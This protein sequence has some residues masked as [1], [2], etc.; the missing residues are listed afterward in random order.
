M[1]QSLTLL[2]FKDDRVQELYLPL[3]LSSLQWRFKMRLRAIPLIFLLSATCHGAESADEVDSFFDLPLQD[4]L[5][6][7]VVTASGHTQSFKEAPA[8]LSVITAD[9]IARWQY[10]SVGEALQQVPGIHC[11]NDYVSLNCGVRGINGGLKGYSKVLKVMIDGQ[12]ISF[13]SDTTNYLGPELIPITVIERIEV[14]RS[15]TSALYG[16]NAFLGVINIITKMPEK[17]GGSLLL[18][19][20]SQQGKPGYGLATDW[21]VS[22][23]HGDFSI[24]VSQERATRDGLEIPDTLPRNS[25]FTPGTENRN[26]ETRPASAYL[27]WRYQLEKHQLYLQGHYSHLDSDAQFVDFG[28]FKSVGELGYNQRIALNNAFIKI[29][30]DITFTDTFSLHVALAYAEGSPSQ[31]E[32]LDVGLET[33]IPVR[34]FGFKATDLVTEINYTPTPQHFITLG[35]DLANDNEELFEAFFENRETGESILTTKAQG[36][37]TFRERGYY[38]QYNGNL[39][40]NMAV[41]LNAR[42]DDHNIYGNE[43]T[44][45]VGVTHDIT[46][47][48]NT[49]LIYGTS[50][51][52]P[53]AIQ[54]YGQSIF[55]GDV[56]G[57]QH[58]KPETAKTLEAQL[59]WLLDSN[60]SLSISAYKSQVSDKVELTPDFDF[61]EQSNSGEENAWGLEGE[62]RFSYAQ[63]QFAASGAFQ[64]TDVESPEL[65]GRLIEAPSEMYPV[66]SWNLNWHFTFDNKSMVGLSWRY[67]SERRGTIS[68]FALNSLKA[69]ELD[70]YHLLDLVASMPFD[71]LTVKLKVKNLLNED[72]EEP[73]FSGI[74]IPGQPIT[75]ILGAQW[76]FQ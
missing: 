19:A 38:V 22:G 5:E 10:Q 59:N 26:D 61:L 73:G 21:H 50:F 64:Q 56:V 25:A 74:D 7:N 68:N 29:A 43:S 35:F 60:L 63:H 72:Y 39:T 46:D 54:L 76:A 14:V 40:D 66:L 34:K 37:R 8:I 58:L 47:R 28:T 55:S 57:N 6:I 67:A 30:D 70:A 49:K 41:L 42:L 75:L 27:T 3:A 16:A 33:S 62:F 65:L 15:P 32:K 44:Y 31:D 53:G 69:Y 24:A 13:R 1:T 36:N 51:K 12:P 18:Q 23:A 52:A 2:P 45:R 71:N 17:E 4:L 20:Q 48:M 9:E 11:I